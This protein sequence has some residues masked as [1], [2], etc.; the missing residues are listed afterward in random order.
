MKVFKLFVVL[1]FSSIAFTSCS[2]DS[3]DDNSITLGE[4]LENYELW[5]VDIH[6]TSGSGDV[7][8][9]SRAFTLSFN[10]GRLYA[11]NNIVDIGYTGN[12]LGIEVGDYDTFA[13]ELQTFHTIDGRFN[14]EVD[15]I[16]LNEIRLRDLNQNVSYYLIGYQRRNFDYDKLFYD[17]IEYFLQEYHAWERTHIS[18]ASQNHLFDS[19]H[20]LAFTPENNTTF[21]SSNDVFGTDID[22]IHWNFTGSYEVFDVL[23]YNNVKALNLNYD[24][25]DI[26]E[27]DL[28][29]L[30]DGTIE[31]YNINTRIIYRFEGRGFIQFLKNSQKNKNIVRNNGRKR[32]IIQRQTIE[33][34][35]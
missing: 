33:R 23:G 35:Q 3:F 28:T 19:E 17:N 24:N 20:F 27:F 6:R 18:D 9:I 8:F 11:N 22:N 13:T 10:H 26:E 30:N 12:G 32:T 31:L 15:Q 34:K 14:F 4:L 5:Y 2:N 29:V 21:Y 7:P 25:G 16:S 1:I